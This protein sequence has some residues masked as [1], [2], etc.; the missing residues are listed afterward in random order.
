MTPTESALCNGSAFVSKTK[1]GGSIPPVG[2]TIKEHMKHLLLLVCLSDCSYQ[3]SVSWDW[4]RSHTVAEKLEAHEA[5][6]AKTE[7]PKRPDRW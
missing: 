2:E 6:I 5:K 7:E 4:G 1:G 3:A